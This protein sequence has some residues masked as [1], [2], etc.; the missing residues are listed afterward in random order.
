MQVGHSVFHKSW[1]YTLW[2]HKR[3]SV[4]LLNVDGSK[5]WSTLSQILRVVFRILGRLKVG[6]GVVL[7][8]TFCYLGAKYVFIF[9]HIE[10]EV[11]LLLGTRI[12]AGI[13]N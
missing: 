2:N 4:L 1:T 3:V 10:F 7:Y 8:R 11:L 5:I 12:G 9:L 6:H 13:I